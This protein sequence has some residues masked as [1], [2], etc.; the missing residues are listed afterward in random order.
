MKHPN[1]KV[2]MLN[3]LRAKSKMLSCFN[4]WLGTKKARAKELLTMRTLAE[5]F[6]DM[7]L[8]QVAEQRIGSKT[9]SVEL[10]DL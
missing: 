9:V 2:E 10:N 4:F 1:K 8:N 3:R 6:V 5:A 7:A